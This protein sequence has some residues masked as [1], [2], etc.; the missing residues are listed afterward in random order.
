MCGAGDGTRFAERGGCGAA[1]ASRTFDPSCAEGGRPP[2]SPAGGGCPSAPRISSSVAAACAA[3][4]GLCSVSK[5]SN[6]SA[7]VCDAA[8]V[9]ELA[10]A[11]SN[12]SKGHR[13]S[14]LRSLAVPAGLACSC[15]AATALG[16]SFAQEVG[17]R[18]ENASELAPCA[19]A[20][21]ESPFT[22]ALV[23]ACGRV[24]EDD[25]DGGLTCP[26][27]AC[28]GAF[29]ASPGKERIRESKSY[30]DE[31]AGARSAPPDQSKLAR[32]SI[33]REESNTPLQAWT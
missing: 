9:L 23:D 3:R 33:A 20:A 21:L 22:G 7:G 4:G 11:F 25:C 5:S 16:A 26:T 2:A 29:R 6:A 24:A 18:L 19:V 14:G 28:A 32:S 30:D 15:S 27:P 1:H 10:C 31:P 17:S 8:G 12:A 13:S